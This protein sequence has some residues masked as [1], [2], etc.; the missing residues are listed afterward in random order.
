MVGKE[1]HHTSLHTSC[2]DTQHQALERFLFV[3]PGD[4][5]SLFGS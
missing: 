3:L 2:A 5:S 4:D 1:H